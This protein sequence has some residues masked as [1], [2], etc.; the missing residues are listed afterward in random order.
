MHR[1]VRRQHDEGRDKTIHIKFI[2]SRLIRAVPLGTRKKTRM[3]ARALRPLE[4]L[5]RIPAPSPA[6]FGGLGTTY[7]KK[8][9]RFDCPSKRVLSR[10]SRFFG[11]N[12]VVNGG[13][14]RIKILRPRK[15]TMTLKLMPTSIHCNVST[16]QINTG[17][18]YREMLEGRLQH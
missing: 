15:F 6:G 7:V 9:S 18:A 3:K 10:S 4:A 11:E 13:T 14:K 16:F 1:L 12:A 17:Q 5:V 2:S 8:K